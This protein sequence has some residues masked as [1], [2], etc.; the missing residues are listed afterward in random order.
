MRGTYLGISLCT[1]HSHAASPMLCALIPC[2]VG[3]AAKH[4]RMLPIGV[5]ALDMVLT[6]CPINGA[7]VGGSPSLRWVNGA[8]LPLRASRGLGLFLACVGREGA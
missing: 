5:R 1:F 2:V 8:L 4:S 6:S 3:W 7:L